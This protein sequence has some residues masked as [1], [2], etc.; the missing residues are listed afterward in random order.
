MINARAETLAEKPS[1]K[2]LFA[3]RRLLVP[4]AGFYEWK[5]VPGQKVKQPFFIHRPDGLP[6]AAAGLWTVW[7]DPANEDESAWLHSCTIITTAANRLVSSLHDRMPAFLAPD[8]WDVWLD[9]DVHSTDV[10]SR[11][12]VPSPEALLELVPVS[13]EVNSVRNKGPHLVD[14]VDTIV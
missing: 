7:R 6:L 9:P 12:L 2:R 11:L 8:D 10:L 13:T 1:F 4:M 5:A 3:T 14:R